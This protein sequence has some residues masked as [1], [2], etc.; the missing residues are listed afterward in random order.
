M[1]HRGK[2]TAIKPHTLLKVKTGGGNWNAVRAEQG[3]GVMSVEAH[4]SWGA[5]LTSWGLSPGVQ[6]RL[7]HR[8]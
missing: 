2:M 4:A 5:E 6:P 7:W 8:S 3:N 1:I